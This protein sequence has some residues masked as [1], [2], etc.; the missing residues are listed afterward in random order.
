MQRKNV[1][2]DNIPQV[3]KYVKLFILQRD[4]LKAEQEAFDERMKP[5]KDHQ[6][7]LKGKLQAFL[8]ATKQ[9][10]SKTAEGTFFTSTK[11]RASISDVN[12]FWRFVVGGELWDLI[13]K[14]ANATA[15]N[16]F[17]EENKALPPGITFSK[18][19]SVNVRRPSD[20]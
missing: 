3:D 17:L 1:M 14:K 8:T 13:D 15:I 5:V 9:E 16:D 6:E 10:S 12:E 2:P 18:E 20:K 19:T 11:P 4:W 7:M